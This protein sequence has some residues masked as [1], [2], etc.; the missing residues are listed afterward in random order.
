MKLIKISVLTT[1]T[2]TS[3]WKD[4]FQLLT[5]LLTKLRN[6]LAPNSLYKLMQLVSVESHLYDLDRGKITDLHKF[7]KKLHNVVLSGAVM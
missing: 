2:T 6:T 7:L 4:D 3:V 5:L 1:S